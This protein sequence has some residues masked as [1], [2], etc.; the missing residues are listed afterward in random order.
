MGILSDLEPVQ[1]FQYFEE[2]C[3]I[4]HGSGNTKAISD[5]C[6]D[7]AKR[8][9]LRYQQ[10]G[11]G[12]VIIWKDGSTGYEQSAPVMLQGHLDMVCEKEA[13][14]EVDF[15]RDGLELQLKDGE[16]SAKGTTLGGD[17]GIAVAYALA[18]LASDTIAHPPLEVVLTVDE[19]IGMLG[20]AVFDASPLQSRIML[21]L[22]S[23]EEGYL[24]VS[25]AGGITTTAHLPIH[26]EKAEGQNITLTVCG[27]QGG[28]SGVEIGKGRGN[29][30]QLLGRAL[31]HLQ[32]DFAFRLC[33]V[34]GGLKDNAIPREA[35]AEL[36][37]TG[38]QQKQRLD[39]ETERHGNLGE[40]Q[41][42]AGTQ[43]SENQGKQL[44]EAFRKKIE[45]IQENYQQEYRLTD[46][47]IR[48][49]ADCSE[50]A[51]R[52]DA[53]DGN[54]TT[55]IITMLYCLPGGIQKMSFAIEGLVQT[56]LNLG[57]L[58]TEEEEVTAS[59]SIRSS[60]ETEKLDLVAKIRC[61]M[62]D[63]EGR[64]T[65]QGEYPAWEYRQDSP[66]R[67][68]MVE[69]FR[70]QYGWEPEVQ[71]LHAG[72]ECGLFAGKL[73]GL[74]CVSFGPDMR[75]IHTPKESMDVESVKRV[76]LYTLEILKRL[77]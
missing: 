30:C 10:D 60:V 38:W 32:N 11:A 42:D 5:Y 4:P 64:I 17:D 63:L 16:I 58:Q 40:Q 75:D 53:I 31:Y 77:G 61:L 48:L 51:V 47:G 27:L 41:L 13:D 14:C 66:L 36:V 20:A 3:H 65:N 12:N 21:N 1:V 67:D 62:E 25:C 68:L 6:V 26:R 59:F 22:D 37:L 73:P 19:E 76:W 71:A 72:V 69:V 54:G 49:M 7:F 56:S 50:N 2:I 57:I 70:E 44:L 55:K 35:A 9:G 15:S 52:D 29:A 39:T 74:D 8:Q 45:E 28:H 23:E 43:F 24:L 33:S 18:I 46:P 34:Q